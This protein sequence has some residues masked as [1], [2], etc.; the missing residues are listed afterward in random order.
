MTAMKKLSTVIATVFMLTGLPVAAQTLDTYALKDFSPSTVR[1]TFEVCR[2]TKLTPAQ[3]ISLAKAIEDENALFVKMV[4]GNNGV[5]AVKDRNR[6]NKMRD[7]TLRKL[8]DDE[9]LLQYYRG[10]YDAE[11]LA[12]GT[13]IANDL[14]KK[15]NLTDQNWKFIRIAFY[16]IGLDSRVLKKMMADNPAKARKEIERIRREQ[17]MTIEEKG[18]IRVNDDMTVDVIRP[19]DPVSLRK[20]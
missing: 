8:L 11:A 20:E 1:E 5:L 16:K 18:G 6:L 3:Q 7:N 4:A 19:F 10:V 12:E 2:H 9:T 13:G 17:L 15:Y 14:Q